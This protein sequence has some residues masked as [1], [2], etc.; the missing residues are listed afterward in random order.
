MACDEV[1]AWFY[2][3]YILYLY[4]YLFYYQRKKRV[5][6]YFPLLT[7]STVV[8]SSHFGSFICS[9]RGLVCGLLVFV[10]KLTLVLDTSLTCNLPVHDRDGSDL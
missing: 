4:L 8:G 3:L 10:L 5:S 1:V 2:I 9:W 7:V 6:C